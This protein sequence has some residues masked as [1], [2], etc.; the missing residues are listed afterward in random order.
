MPLGENGLA[1]TNSRQWSGACQCAGPREQP[2]ETSSDYTPQRTYTCRR[3]MRHPTPVS[4][5]KPLHLKSRSQS[6]K[7]NIS[8]QINSLPHAPP[9]RR[10]PK[11]IRE[12]GHTPQFMSQNVS[13]RLAA[14]TRT[15]SLRLARFLHGEHPPRDTSVLSILRSNASRAAALRRPSTQARARGS[16]RAL[17]SIESAAGDCG[18]LGFPAGRPAGRRVCTR[19]SVASGVG[20]LMSVRRSLP[21]SV[22][23]VGLQDEEDAV[24]RPLDAGFADDYGFAL[25]DV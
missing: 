11:C 4:Q 18:C 25:R 1:V 3:P 13:R 7:K 6:Y 21:R 14:I 10:H 22:D 5:P 24:C 17:G 23:D 12:A 9:K 15:G 8:H 19:R 16:E 20:G 2:A